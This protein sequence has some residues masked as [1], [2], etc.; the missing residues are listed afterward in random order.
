MLSRIAALVSY[1]AFIALLFVLILLQGAWEE[2]NGRIKGRRRKHK[3]PVEEELKNDGW[4]DAADSNEEQVIEKVGKLQV[5][6]PR[7][8]V[9]VVAKVGKDMEGDDI[10]L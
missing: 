3:L 9:I 10:I 7:P 8:P 1:T 5:D 4:E 2:I 6:D